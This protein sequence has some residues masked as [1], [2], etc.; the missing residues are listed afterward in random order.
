MQAFKSGTIPLRIKHEEIQVGFITSREFPNLFIFPKGHIDK[1]ET[2]EKAALRETREE[3]GWSGKIIGNP[4]CVGKN[5]K[6][7][8][9]SNV[10]IAYYPLLVSKISKDWPEKKYRSRVWITVDMLNDIKIDKCSKN[11]IAELQAINGS[12]L[13][14]LLRDQGQARLSHLS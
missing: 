3:A 6:I 9:T 13:G 5:F 8:K 10:Y 1:K 7:A 12:R 2:I 4:I 11:I 14:H